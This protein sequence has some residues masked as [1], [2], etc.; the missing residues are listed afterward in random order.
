MIRG[1][2]KGIEEIKR[3]RWA[4]FSTS[5]VENIG[6]MK[7]ILENIRETLNRPVSM[8]ESVHTKGIKFS[9]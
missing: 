6:K 8:H 3:N 1:S 2:T 9:F 4:Q 7:S 5:K